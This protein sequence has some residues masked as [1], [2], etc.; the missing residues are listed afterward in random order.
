MDALIVEGRRH[1]RV[2]YSYRKRKP[3]SETVFKFHHRTVLQ[4]LESRIEE[5]FEMPIPI[6]TAFWLDLK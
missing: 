3:E 2:A 4:A 5:L 6:N 1:P